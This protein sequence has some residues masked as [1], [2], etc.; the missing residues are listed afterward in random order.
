MR[1][2][3]GAAALTAVA[4]GAA[5]WWILPASAGGGG[6][7]HDDR[8]DTFRVEVREVDAVD[9]DLGER[10]FGIGDRFVFTEDLVKHGKVVGSD[11]GE[12]TLTRLHGAGGWFQCT[13]T[14]VFYGKGQITVQGAFRFSEGAESQRFALPVT[15]GS[16]KFTG[17]DGVVI[18]DEDADSSSLTFKLR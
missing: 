11:H 18:V 12:C 17:A 5:G 3:Y 9:L 14:A 6:G 4:L 1:R 13:A 2:S 10:G 15:G 8:G 16:G 7:G